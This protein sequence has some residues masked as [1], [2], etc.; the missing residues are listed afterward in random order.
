[1]S[2]KGITLIALI[3]TIIV[4]LVLATVSVSV[5]TSGNLIMRTKEIKLD[6]KVTE[7]KETIRAV[8][9]QVLGTMEYSGVADLA[10]KI[11]EELVKIKGL[12]E[13][14]VLIYGDD[15]VVSMPGNVQLTFEEATGKKLP[16]YLDY[17]VTR[18]ELEGR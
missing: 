1:M 18:T 2:K 14:T 13:V 5:I 7:A 12:E 15:Y 8:T 6:E 9:N 11:E 17:Y 3:V 4:L 10:V 16:L